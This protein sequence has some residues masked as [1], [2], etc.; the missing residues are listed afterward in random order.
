MAR[1]VRGVRGKAAVPRSSSLVKDTSKLRTAKT[2]SGRGTFAPGYKL[3][4]TGNGRARNSVQNV[5]IRKVVNP[6][7]G[8]GPA[9]V[10][11][12]GRYANM[13]QRVINAPIIRV[14]RAAP[15]NAG[16]RVVRPPKTAIRI[17]GR[18]PGVVRTI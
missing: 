3:I 14:P 11:A 2:A 15:A 17:G 12:G 7:G 4:G 10:G 18:G 16:S 6:L 13:N 8:Q 9:K 5:P 1:G